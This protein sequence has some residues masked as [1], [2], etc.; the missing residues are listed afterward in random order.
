MNDH[1]FL[2]PEGTFLPQGEYAV[3]TT[4]SVAFR[5]HFPDVPSVLGDL[6]FNLGNGGDQIRIYDAEGVLVDSV[7]YDDEPPWPVEPD[8]QG[9]TLQLLDPVYPNEHAYNWRASLMPHG[10]P[11]YGYVSSLILQMIENDDGC[12]LSWSTWPGASAYRVYGAADAWFFEPQLSFPFRYLLQTLPADVSTCPVPSGIGE[13]SANWSYLVLATNDLQQELV[14]SN[15]VGE[16][17]ADL[18]VIQGPEV[19]R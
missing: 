2:I 10:D 17:D 3:V 8:G 14:R 7:G 9:P 15:R 6:G 11:G 4:D 13:S 1:Q 16:F 12:A 5:E 19:P 18:E